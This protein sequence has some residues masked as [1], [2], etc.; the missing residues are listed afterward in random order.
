MIVRI[1]VYVLASWLIA[2]HFLRSGNLALTAVCLAAPLLFPVR[3]RW[4]LLLAQ[5]LAYVACA[6]WL[7]TTWQIVAMRRVFGL[8]WLRSAIILLSVAAV[9]AAAGLLLRSRTMQVRYRAR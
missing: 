3:R 2:A 5:F 1:I 9:T 7:L 6:V 8:P 4:S